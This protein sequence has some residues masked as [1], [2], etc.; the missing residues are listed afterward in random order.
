MSSSDDYD[1]A[2]AAKKTAASR[3]SASKLID[4][5]KAPLKPREYSAGGAIDLRADNAGKWGKHY[6]EVRGKMGYL[7]TI[8]GEE[9]N[10]VHE[11]LRVFD[12]SYKYG[13]CIGITRLERWQRAQ[14]LGLNPPVEVHEILSTKQGIEEDEFKHC[15]FYG[16]V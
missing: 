15:V 4:K 12:T 8:H 11:I 14:A 5:G 16:I 13:P 2:P 7:A 9:Q 1:E 6:G 10:K 3:P